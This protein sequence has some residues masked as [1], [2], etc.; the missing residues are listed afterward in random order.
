MALDIGVGWLARDARELDPTE[1]AQQLE[2]FDRLNEVLADARMKPHHEPLDIPEDDVFE[3]GLGGYQILQAVRRL[4]A[5][6]GLLRRLPTPDERELT[7]SSDPVLQRFYRVHRTYCGLVNDYPVLTPLVRLGR[8]GPRFPHLVW[9]SDAEGFYL[10]RDFRE[11]VMD[12]SGVDRGVPMVGSSARLL[13]ECRELA[14]RIGLPDEIDMDSDA[15]WAAGER[16]RFDG[17]AWEAFGPEAFCL[18]RLMRGCRESLRLK[19]VLA[20]G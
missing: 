14:G 17:A 19:A 5:F 7:P 16:R 3:T 15:L 1:F 10:P 11:V 18:A 4:A 13:E 9:H 2:V 6:V 8:P 20:F 12:M